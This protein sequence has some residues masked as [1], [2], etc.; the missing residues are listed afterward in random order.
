MQKESEYQSRFLVF[1]PRIIGYQLEEKHRREKKQSP[2]QAEYMTE[3][4]RILFEN[5]YQNPENNYISM[6]PDWE[7]STGCKCELGIANGLG[8]NVIIEKEAIY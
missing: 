2:T 6:H 4:A 8:I 3:C 7:I 5:F 1:S